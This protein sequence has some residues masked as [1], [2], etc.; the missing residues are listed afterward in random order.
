MLS[1][2][3]TRCPSP[4]PAPA[5]PTTAVSRPSTPRRC[6]RSPTAAALAALACPPL[7]S[8]AHHRPRAP[9]CA[10]ARLPPPSLP[11]FACHR[12]RPVPR[13]HPPIAAPCRTLFVPQA[14]SYPVPPSARR[15]LA[16]CVPCAALSASRHARRTAFAPA[17]VF[18]PAAV[19]FGPAAVIF[20]P[21]PP[22][23]PLRPL[24]PLPPSRLPRRPLDATRSPSS[25]H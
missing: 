8:F 21:P 3:S 9:V 7:P 6:P 13:P 5:R 23:H 11:S 2:A 15:P 10:L 22:L 20:G 4:S 17:V 16:V 14:T 12:P 25:A 1:I 19:V 18:G 24:C